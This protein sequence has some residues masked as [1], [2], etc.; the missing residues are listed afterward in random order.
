VGGGGGGG[1]DDY[2]CAYGPILSVCQNR[3]S[4]FPTLITENTSNSN[5]VTNSFGEAFVT[6]SMRSHALFNPQKL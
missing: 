6:E 2:T 3:S 5:T 4:L 1:C